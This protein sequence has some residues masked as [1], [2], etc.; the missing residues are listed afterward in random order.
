MKLYTNIDKYAINPLQ[1]S[2]N[3]YREYGHSVVDIK[4][5]SRGWEN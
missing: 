5:I 2:Q 1:H 3:V 4:N